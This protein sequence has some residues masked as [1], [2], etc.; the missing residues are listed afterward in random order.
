MN[1]SNRKTT[2][3]VNIFLFLILLLVFSVL[4]KI[5]QLD[6]FSKIHSG[7]LLLLWDFVFLTYLLFGSIFYGFV[8]KSRLLSA[9]LGALFPLMSFASGLFIL[10]YDSGVSY[11]IESISDLSPYFPFLRIALFCALSGFFAATHSSNKTVNEIN[12]VLTAV[13]FSLSFVFL[14]VW[15]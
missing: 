6:L 4:L 5:S 14:F 12:Y 15:F 11:P 2:T 13:S 9:L 8:T 10:F 1:S 3:K 7:I